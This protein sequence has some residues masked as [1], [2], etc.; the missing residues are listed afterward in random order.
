[1][2]TSCTKCMRRF[3]FLLNTW[4]HKND[5]MHRTTSDLKKPWLNCFSYYMTH[6]LQKSF[7]PSH[8]M[9]HFP[10]KASAISLHDSFP[11]GSFQ[12][13]HYMIHF[14]QE[15]YMSHN[16]LIQIA[17]SHFITWFISCRKLSV[18]RLHDS[19]P[20]ESFLSSHYTSHF[21]QKAFSHLITWFISYRKLSVIS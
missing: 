9:S 12:P 2:A 5:F 19:F 4:S 10:Q 15:A 6:F 11:T 8:N 7:L 18:I 13:S 21:L 20:A 17:F 16:H 14:L 1:M 3:T